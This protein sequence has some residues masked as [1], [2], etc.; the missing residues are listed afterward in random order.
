MSRPGIPPYAITFGPSSNCTLDI[1]NVRYS[2]YGFVPSLAA[3]ASFLALF[4]IAAAAHSYLGWRWKTPLFASFMAVGCVSAI[5][6]YVGRLLLNENPFDFPGF[7][8]QIIGVTLAPVYFCAA[9][10]ITLAK[11]IEELAP[12]LSR[13]PPRYFYYI[14]IPCDL[15]SLVVQGAGGIL[16][17]STSGQSQIGVNLAL[18]GLAFQVFTIVVFCGFFIDFLWRYFHSQRPTHRQ[19]SPRIRVFFALLAFSVLL[20]TIRCVYRLAELHEGYSGTLVRDE[21]LYIAFEGVLGGILRL[22]LIIIHPIQNF[23]LACERIDRNVVCDY[24]RQGP[25]V[26]WQAGAGENQNLERACT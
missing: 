12:E 10:Y 6:G 3:N 15:I 14:L 26:K 4:T 7:L 5:V 9:I 25:N 2:V 21:P 23:P 19:I 18:A 11:T 16:S 1:C 22:D 8:I 20:I 13:I 17:T 24:L